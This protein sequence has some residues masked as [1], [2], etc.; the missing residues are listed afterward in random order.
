[1]SKK[2]AFIII[3]FVIDSKGTA[4]VAVCEK[5]GV[6]KI[7]FYNVGLTGV[8]PLCGCVKS[9]LWFKFYQ[10]N[11]S[12]NDFLSLQKQAFFNTLQA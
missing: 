12:Y 7:T 6:L 3:V 10:N 9:K 8:S 4:F 5:K 2:I 1:M 11:F